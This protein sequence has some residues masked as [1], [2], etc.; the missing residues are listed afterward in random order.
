MII[1][2]SFSGRN[3]VAGFQY[4]PDQFFGDRFSICSRQRNYRNIKL[5]PVKRCQLLQCFKYI[6][7]QNSFVRNCIRLIINDSNQCTFCNSLVSKLICI[8]VR[9]F[10]CKKHFVRANI[11]C[12]CRNTF[13]FQKKFV[14]IVQPSFI[15][16]SAIL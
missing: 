9:P 10:Q 15:H 1:Q 12:I 8:E 16:D 5:L 11:T 3:P 4:G 7:H 6:F 14:D 13:A 2:I